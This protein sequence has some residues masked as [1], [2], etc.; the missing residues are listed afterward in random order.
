MHEA[1]KYLVAA[2]S[3]AGFVGFLLLFVATFAAQPTL[4]EAM[5]GF[6]RSRVHQEVRER[7][8]SAAAADATLLKQWFEGSAE[9]AADFLEHELEPLVDRLL[10]WC[11]ATDHPDKGL[12][13]RGAKF[14]RS[15]FEPTIERYGAI[16]AELEKFIRGKYTE[17][18]HALMSEIRLFSGINTALF[19]SA[20]ALLFAKWREPRVVLVPATLLLIA[21]A[22]CIAVYVFGQNWFFSIFLQD[23]AGYGYLAYVSI[24]FGLLLDIAFNRGRMTN[25][26]L[27]AFTAPLA[28]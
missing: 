6:V 5:N 19:A 14:V 26:V 21:T 1:G 25:G 15:A 20:L 17:L 8:G 10:D 4:E 24:V 13:A 28:S 22:V 12:I 16:A 18:V 11:S 7:F 3:L 9:A 23:Y 2:A 27:S